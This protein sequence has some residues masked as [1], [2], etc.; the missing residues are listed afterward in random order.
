MGLLYLTFHLIFF[1][2]IDNLRI[3]LCDDALLKL[4]ISSAQRLYRLTHKFLFTYND[5]ADL[6][7]M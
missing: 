3:R 6:K 1:Y 5:K 7:P 2:T 4:L